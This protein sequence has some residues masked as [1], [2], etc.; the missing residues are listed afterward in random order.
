VF[1]TGR[2]ATALIPYEERKKGG[3]E[4]YTR[5]EYLGL[6][7]KEKRECFNAPSSKGDPRVGLA[8]GG[9][10]GISAVDKKKRIT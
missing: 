2:S 10:K 6:R 4:T 1:G 9:Q 8:D 3:K 5:V 7:E